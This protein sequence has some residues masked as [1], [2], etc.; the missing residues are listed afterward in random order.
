MLF[1]EKADQGVP[2]VLL[3]VPYRKDK[4]DHRGGEF[5]WNHG[6]VG[7]PVGHAVFSISLIASRHMSN[8]VAR[9][10]KEGTE[11]SARGECV[12]VQ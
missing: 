6:P 4:R 8:C 2:V 11:K 10:R 5:C 12:R 9:E 1:N 7:R 3:N